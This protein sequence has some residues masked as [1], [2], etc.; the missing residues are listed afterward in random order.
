LAEPDTERLGSD[1]FLGVAQDMIG[2]TRILGCTPDS[3]EKQV[4]FKPSK[5]ASWLHFHGVGCPRVMTVRVAVGDRESG[6]LCPPDER[7]GD[8][9]PE[10]HLNRSASRRPS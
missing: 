7:F 10:T 1:A 5:L 3:S 2:D 8:R 9:R 4:L 6:G